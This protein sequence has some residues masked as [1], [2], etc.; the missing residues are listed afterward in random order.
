MVL[1]KTALPCEEIPGERKG[2]IVYWAGDFGYIKDTSRGNALYLK[3]RHAKPLGCKGRATMSEGDT[4]MFV[5]GVHICGST[6]VDKSV[7][8][9]KSTLKRKAADMSE[10]GNKDIY[11]RVLS[12][13]PEVQGELSFPQLEPSMRRARKETLPT[14]PTSIKEAITKLEDRENHPFSEVYIGTVNYE[15]SSAVL[16]GNLSQIKLM[17]ESSSAFVDATFSIVP[18]G[19]DQ[20][21]HQLLI[22]Q[23]EFKNVVIPVVSALMESK[24][25]GLYEAVFQKIKELAPN[26]LPQNLMADFELGMQNSL[27]KV[28][29]DGDVRGCRFHFG[30]ALM[31]KIGN[32]KL[33]KDYRS[34]RL[35]RKW[36]RK[37][38]AMC[39]LPSEKIQL[40]WSQHCMGLV[41]FNGDLRKKLNI[42][43][44][45]FER[46]WMKNVTPQ[47][48]SVFG[49]TNKTNNFSESFNSAIKKSFKVSHPGFWVFFQLWKENVI[50][51]TSEQLACIEK[52]RPPRRNRVNY[53]D[54]ETI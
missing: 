16:L 39:T 12:Q 33:I 54:I 47:C 21:F 10:G 38:M 22:F 30:Q 6:E 48:F 18:K 53:A 19:L 36:L 35:V 41:A 31:R 14:N 29:N 13:N 24:N 44:R 4:E 26:F 42:F 45:Y 51:V 32:L 27:K 8:L 17:A 52:T 9:V 28:W 20:E 50:D 3:C 11:N 23:I 25:Q 37:S 1:I 2:S 7:L 5:K 49:I 46:F 40:A 43:R 15:S 34:N